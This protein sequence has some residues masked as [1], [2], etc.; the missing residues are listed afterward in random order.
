MPASN[1]STADRSGRLSSRRSGLSAAPGQLAALRRGRR[2]RTGAPDRAADHLSVD[3]HLPSRCLSFPG[4]NSISRRLNSDYFL[5]SLH[6]DAR[7]RPCAASSAC[8]SRTRR[9]SPSSGDDRRDARGAVR[10]RA[11]QRRLRGLWAEGPAARSSRSAAGSRPA[12]VAAA[13]HLAAS[14]MPRSPRIPRHPCRRRRSP[15]RRR[16]KSAAWLAREAPDATSS[17]AATAWSSTRRSAGRRRRRAFRLRAMTGTHGIGH[18]RMATESAV[19]TDGAHPFS[20]GPDQCLV[21]NGSLSNHN[22]LRRDA[23]AARAFASR[24][25]TTPRSPPAISPGACARA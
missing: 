25:R 5:S 9:S 11:R 14:S 19:T 16:R 4:R 7:D 6:F 24:P 23:A 21:H 3:H 1:S 15:S 2:P 8:F 22:D 10:P 17:A 20:T 18:T 12:I 13:A